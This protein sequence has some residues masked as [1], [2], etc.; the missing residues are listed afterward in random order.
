MI[1]HACNPSYSGG[2]GRRITVW[3][4]TPAKAQTEEQTKQNELEA[5]LKQQS[6][7]L[8]SAKS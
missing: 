4:L 8:A 1:M 5:W 2:S 3:R 6:T 7:C